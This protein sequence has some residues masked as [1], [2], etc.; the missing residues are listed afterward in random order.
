MNDYK[1]LE[2]WQRSINLVKS[3]YLLLTYLPANEKYALID[4]IRRSAVSIPSNIA[5]GHDRGSTKEFIHFLYT[6]LG[7]SSELETQLILINKLYNINIDSVLNELTVIKK[8]VNKI[9]TS[10]KRKI[11]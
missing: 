3:V 1:E 9:I 7:S 6:A 2:V 10:L 5:E 8:M 11:T 4:Q